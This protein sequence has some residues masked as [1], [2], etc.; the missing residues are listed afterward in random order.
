QMFAQG[1]GFY[2][3]LGVLWDRAGNDQYTAVR[4]AQGTA[5]HE[6]A[7]LLDDAAG[8]DRY[9]LTVGVGQGMGLDL[10][11]GTL[12]DRDGDDTY[13][14]MFLSQGTATANGF[15]LLADEAGAN[16]FDMS[17]DPRSW[18]AG[19]WLRGLPSVGVLAADRAHA[20][21]SRSS[22]QVPPQYSGK[23]EPDAAPDC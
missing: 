15:G 6:A 3:S 5:A 4:Y 23:Q 10:A 11:V 16:T 21:F 2:Y 1:S 7:G 8:D 12:V 14:S 13:R 22:V 17:A 18:G 9:A 20:R 19:Q